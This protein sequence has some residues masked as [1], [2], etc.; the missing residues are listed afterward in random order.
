MTPDAFHI[1]PQALADVCPGRSPE[2]ALMADALARF[3]WEWPL[4]WCKPLD[5]RDYATHVSSA[6]LL[7]LALRVPAVLGR[8][9]QLPG[10][11][12]AAG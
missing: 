4:R 12:P 6:D 5:D 1:D 9:W 3:A 8:A 7:H 11:E 10:L 2:T